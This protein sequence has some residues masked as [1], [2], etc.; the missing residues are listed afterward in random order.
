MLSGYFDSDFWSR[1]VMQ[2][3]HVEPTI[4]HAVMAVSFLHE[5]SE[6]SARAPT[7]GSRILPLVADP[8]NKFALQHYNSAI[9]CLVENVDS[10]HDQ[11]EELALLTCLL[12]ICIEFLQARVRP[13]MI[14][15]EQGL[16]ILCRSEEQAYICSPLERRSK[17]ILTSALVTEHLFPLFSRLSLLPPMFGS[18]LASLQ[19]TILS[20]SSFLSILDM[21]STFSTLIDARSTLVQ[22][23]SLCLRFVR[24]TDTV[25]FNPVSEIENLKQMVQHQSNLEEALE[26]WH[27]AFL[28]FTRNFST[29]VTR[30]EGARNTEATVAINNSKI[31]RVYHV[32]TTIW[33]R[34]ALIPSESSF[35]Q[36]IQ[37]FS[38]IVKLTSSLLLSESRPDLDDRPTSTFTFEMGVIPPLYFTAIKCR[39]LPTRMAALSLLRASSTR[40]ENL[41]DARVMARVAERVIEIEHGEQ[42][43]LARDEDDSRTIDPLASIDYDCEVPPPESSRV[44]DA[45]IDQD[46]IQEWSGRSFR[47]KKRVGFLMKPYGIDGDWAVKTEWVRL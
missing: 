35:D 13:A 11:A 45:D 42:V 41:W 36:H 40:R 12:F 39:H 7:F 38:S 28:P 3:S 22:L 20:D 14:H 6:A 5:Q 47:A 4:R 46:L 10:R 24:S 30:V 23:M 9:R 43:S 32:V 15:L 19:E 31:L 37:S 21:P 26:Q 44:Y 29:E 2:I 27:V 33:T 34:T 16:S 25:K 1:L 18:P 17:T 8:Q